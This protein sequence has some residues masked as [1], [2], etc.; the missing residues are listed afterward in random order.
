LVDF[1]NVVPLLGQLDAKVVALS[2]DD[3]ATTQA[4][5]DGLRI[6]SYP[7]LHSADAQQIHELTGAFIE[8]ERGFLHATGFL[9]R[10]DGKVAQAVYATGPIGR[11]TPLDTLKV[12]EFLQRPR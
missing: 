10:P 8:T 7:V 4:L 9:L 12:L 2:V 1:N 11:L 5:V 6:E 3:R